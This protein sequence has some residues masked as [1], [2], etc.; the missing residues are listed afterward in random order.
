MPAL[1]VFEGMVLQKLSCIAVKKKTPR[2]SICCLQRICRN[3]NGV[4]GE[5]RRREPSHT[6]V[7][8]CTGQVNS[9]S[10]SQGRL[11]ELLGMPAARYQA[12]NFV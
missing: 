11:R 6:G 9:N 5:G 10:N 8:Q 12:G 4:I 2:R 7:S 1:Y 3:R